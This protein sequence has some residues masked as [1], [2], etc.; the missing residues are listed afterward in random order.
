LLI[1]SS[2]GQIR[3]E[4]REITIIWLGHA[5]YLITTSDST[6]IMIDPAEFKG[7][8][9]PKGLE[10]DIVTISHN[11]IDHNRVN[12]LEGNPVLLYGCSPDNQTVNTIDTIIKDIKIKS[13]PSYHDPGKHGINAI[14]VIEF[15][16]IRIVHLGDLGTTLTKTQIKDI[17]EVD[18]LMIP[19]GGQFTIAG[20]KADSVINQL[21]VQ[22]MILP[23]HYKTEAFD[24]LPYAADD[25]LKGKENVIRISNN[26]LTIKLDQF[27]G[28]KEYVIMQYNS[29]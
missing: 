22:R 25:F 9:M 24:D 3:A 15:D 7:Y 10:P 16:S 19:V 5:C 8:H 12:M 21:N 11:H 26:R 14:F 4:D 27:P 28:K 20:A 23:M 18:I 17:G 13:V 2:L 1:S 29:E 6:Q